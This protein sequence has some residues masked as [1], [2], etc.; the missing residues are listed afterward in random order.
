MDRFRKVMLLLSSWNGFCLEKLIHC[1]YSK[2]FWHRHF[3]MA[4]QPN[5]LH[6]GGQLDWVFQ[7]WQPTGCIEHPRML[8]IIFWNSTCLGVEYTCLCFELYSYVG[9]HIFEYTFAIDACLF[10]KIPPH[11]T[12]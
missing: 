6:F 10:A 7:L 11:R 3:L 4:W 1:A 9:E 12:S 2:L 5:A 8:T